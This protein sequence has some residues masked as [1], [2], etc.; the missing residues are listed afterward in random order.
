MS[1]KTEAQRRARG[2]CPLCGQRPPLE[3]RAICYT[4]LEKRRRYYRGDHWRSKKAI[5]QQ[6][7]KIRVWLPVPDHE[8]IKTL[9]QM[10]GVAITVWARDAILSYLGELGL[11]P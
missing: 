4:C 9:A 8:Q 1:A 10:E 7:R 6:R 5:R 2:L 11:Q 3:D